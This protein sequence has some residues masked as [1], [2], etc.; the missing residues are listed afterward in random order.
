MRHSADFLIDL[1]AVNSRL[2]LL[3]ILGRFSDRSPADFPAD[4]LADFRISRANSRPTRPISRPILIS[5]GVL[6]VADF[7][8]ILNLAA[9]VCDLSFSKKRQGNRR[10]NRRG[11]RPGNRLEIGG[12][13]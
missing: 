4:F 2:F 3:T 10:E 13:W 7:R 12:R 5:A 1:S 9:P 6:E 11:S 8:P